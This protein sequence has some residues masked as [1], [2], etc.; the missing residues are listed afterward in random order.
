MTEPD[1]GGGCCFIGQDLHLDSS[2]YVYSKENMHDLATLAK[3]P[4]E[5]DAFTNFLA[6]PVTNAYF[7]VFHHLKASGSSENMKE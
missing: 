2:T 3:T 6:G 7:K 1:L 5:E 4:G